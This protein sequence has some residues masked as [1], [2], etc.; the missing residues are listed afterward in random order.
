MNIIIVITKSTQEEM[1]VKDFNES[2]DH[3]LNTLQ[4]WMMEAWEKRENSSIT[5]CKN[6]LLHSIDSQLL[7]HEEEFPNV[8]HQ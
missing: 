5:R 6:E 8:L 1:L 2:I 3:T 7:E 4:L